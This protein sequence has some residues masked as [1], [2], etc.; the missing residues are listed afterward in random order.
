MQAKNLKK[1]AS[2]V[3]ALEGAV[4]R[5]QVLYG[6]KLYRPPTKYDRGL[7]SYRAAEKAIRAPQ[8]SG[9]EGAYLP[10]EKK[11]LAHA[12]VREYRFP[13]ADLAT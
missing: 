12:I 13:K 7:S 6:V 2:D 1:K 3:A 10:A 4:R 5:R 9:V 11:T 8:F